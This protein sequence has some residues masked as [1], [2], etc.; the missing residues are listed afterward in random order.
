MG[1]WGV[2]IFKFIDLIFMA[3]L[4][5]NQSP[6]HGIADLLVLRIQTSQRPT[7]LITTKCCLILHF[8]LYPQPKKRTISL[9]FAK[10][11]YW[12]Q[13]ALTKCHRL[14]VLNNKHLFLTVLEAGS[15]RPRNLADF[16]PGRTLFLAYG[17]SSSPYVLSWQKESS[18][19]SFTSCKDINPIMALFSSHILI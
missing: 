16:I 13:T 9:Y 6:E 5:W 14:C 3:L 7:T 11:A 1:V 12:A 4:F 15:P 19:V 10:K 17:W 8:S 2:K 18:G